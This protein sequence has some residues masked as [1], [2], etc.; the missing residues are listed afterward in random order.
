MAAL[1]EWMLL[2]EVLIS[3]LNS[4]FF[5]WLEFT[6]PCIGYQMRWTS[7]ISEMKH[8]SWR[9][10]GEEGMSF[11]SAMGPRLQRIHASPSK[12]LSLSRKWDLSDLIFLLEGQFSVFSYE[13]TSDVK[14]FEWAQSVKY[15]QY[16]TFLVLLQ[17]SNRDPDRRTEDHFLTILLQ[18]I[19]AW[20][21]CSIFTFGKHFTDRPRFS[22]HINIFF[23]GFLLFKVY[24]PVTKYLHKTF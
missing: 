24:E 12:H 21:K 20:L 18:Y 15:L 11:A 22:E 10:W 16:L 17:V 19:V 23:A 13:S 1:H 7:L 3:T 9:D 6:L 5:Y 14:P 2:T 8:K 4:G